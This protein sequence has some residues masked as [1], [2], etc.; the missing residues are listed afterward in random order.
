MNTGYEEHTTKAKVAHLLHRDDFKLIC[1]TQEELQKE[2]QM[3]RTFSDD[4]HGIQ[5]SQMCKDST[6]GRKISSLAKFNT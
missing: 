6:E 4:I 2:L 3:V 1:K 5:T